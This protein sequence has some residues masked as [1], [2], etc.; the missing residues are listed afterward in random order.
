MK[1]GKLHLRNP[2]DLLIKRHPPFFLLEYRNNGAGIAEG[3]QLPS[4]GDDD[5]RQLNQE[6]Y[7]FCASLGRLF[8]C[9]F[10]FRS[11]KKNVM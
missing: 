4:C 11:G 2:N 7:E 10:V 1:H 9:L 3:V 6:D 5:E 8:V